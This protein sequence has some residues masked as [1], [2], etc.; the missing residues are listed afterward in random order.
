MFLSLILE[1]GL[2]SNKP[3]LTKSWVSL[4]DPDSELDSKTNDKKFA[5]VW[6][7]QTNAQSTTNLWWGRVTEADCRTVKF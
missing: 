6:I 2:S 7:Y 4:N 3:Q 1:I 5:I